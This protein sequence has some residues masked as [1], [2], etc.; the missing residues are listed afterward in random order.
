MENSKPD[1]NGNTF[2]MEFNK[3]FFR[4]GD[5]MISQSCYVQVVSVP[6]IKWYKR[7]LYFIS[8]GY[9]KLSYEYEVKLLN[10]I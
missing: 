9:Y 5:T 8:F 10:K 1:I 3:D 7:L 4:M 6:K 2:T